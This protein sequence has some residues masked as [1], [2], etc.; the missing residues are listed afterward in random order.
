MEIDEV[1]GRIA[2]VA[3]EV[4]GAAPRLGHSRPGPAAFGGDGPGRLG[5]LG[6]DLHAAWGA[7]LAAREREAAGHGARL[8]DLAG[9]LRQAAAG[10]REVEDGAQR[11]HGAV[12]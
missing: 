3:D 9:A 4:S 2:S 1:A 12:A 6:R 11:R 8:T 7:A 10:Y 5:E